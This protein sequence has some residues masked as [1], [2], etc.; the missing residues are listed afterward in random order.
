MGKAR[1]KVADP[2]QLLGWRYVASTQTSCGYSII[3]AGECVANPHHAPSRGRGGRSGDKTIILP[4]NVHA[5]TY[6]FFFLA[7]LFTVASTQERSVGGLGVSLAP[8]TKGLPEPE[9][10]GCLTAADV[11]HLTAE[12]LA[13]HNKQ[14]KCHYIHRVLTTSSRGNALGIQRSKLK[15]TKASA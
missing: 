2:R 9:R 13:S 1:R 12:F 8:Y 6:D 5:I 7:D 10:A 15:N 11:S 14:K 4:S 3:S